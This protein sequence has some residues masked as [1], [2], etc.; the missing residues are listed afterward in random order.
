MAFVFPYFLKCNGMDRIAISRI[1]L[2]GRSLDRA[3]FLVLD[4][5]D[6]RPLY[7]RHNWQTII[8]KKEFRYTRQRHLDVGPDGGA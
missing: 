6:G 2:S 7:G 3:Q 5:I 1:D 4:T 8:G